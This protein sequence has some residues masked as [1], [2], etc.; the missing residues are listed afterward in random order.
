MDFF[1][2]FGDGLQQ[3]LAKAPYTETSGQF[4]IEL[5]ALHACSY[6]FEKWL[7]RPEILMS[8]SCH[9]TTG[10]PLTEDLAARL[11]KGISCFQHNRYVLQ[12]INYNTN[13]IKHGIVKHTQHTQSTSK[14]L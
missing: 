5:D 1:L 8:L 14:K 7:K 6:F 3:I 12:T 2:Q 10:Q 13:T 11:I 9:H 4:S